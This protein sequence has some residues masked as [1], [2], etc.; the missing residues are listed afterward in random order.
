MGHGI[1]LIEDEEVLAKNIKRY[2][3]RRGYDVVTTPT[4]KGELTCSAAT[5]SISCCSI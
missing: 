5:T 3:E 2:L 4:G 1:L